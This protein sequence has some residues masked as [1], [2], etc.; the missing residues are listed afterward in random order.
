MDSSE[1]NRKVTSE[2]RRRGQQETSSSRGEDGQSLVEYGLIIGLVA[3]VLVA[4][5][6]ALS[7]G[8]AGVFTRIVAQLSGVG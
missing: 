7:G 2:P 3:I 6:S 8:I 4:G 1:L 5:L